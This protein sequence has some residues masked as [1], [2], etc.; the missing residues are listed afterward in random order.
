MV[1]SL[2]TSL[3]AFGSTEGKVTGDRVNVRSGPST[4]SSIL[5]KFNT[6]DKIIIASKE[7]DWYKITLANNKIAFIYGEFVQPVDASQ[8][9]VTAEKPVVAESATTTDIRSNLVTFAKKYVGN[10]YVYGGTSLTNGTDCSG[11][12]QSVY[13]NFGYSI[14]RSSSSQ[15]SNGK[16]VKVSELLPGDLVFFG[17]NGS[18]SHVS[19]YI[20]DGK[21]V[22]A[23]TSSTGIIVSGLY[24]R[25][26][27]PFIG[28][29]RII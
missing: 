15:Y 1:F 6:G 13:K 17:Y 23:S 19:I 26:N 5:D 11:F 3:N 8:V 2:F 7:G 16:A 28:C 10:P 12:T 25:G 27:K 14:N 20:G 24:D 29:R 4:S 22:H 21:I 9:I 18:I